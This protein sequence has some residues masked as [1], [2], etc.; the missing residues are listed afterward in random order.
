[1]HP[2]TAREISRLS[3]PIYHDVFDALDSELDITGSEAG[4]VAILAQMAARVGLLIAF[5]E[6][7]AAREE[8]TRLVNR[9]EMF[10]AACE[11]AIDEVLARR[12][13]PELIP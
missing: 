6:P 1:M 5:N 11:E 3:E 2:S 9:A 12:E 8:L 7:E 10:A 4:S 13:Q